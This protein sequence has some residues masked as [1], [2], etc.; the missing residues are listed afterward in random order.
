MQKEKKNNGKMF[1]GSCKSQ[2]QGQIQGGGGDAG[3]RGEGGG[4]E[5]FRG[6]SEGLET[7][8]R[9]VFDH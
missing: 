6:H 9:A 5:Q 4:T 7:E 2:Q 3:R 8:N 1:T